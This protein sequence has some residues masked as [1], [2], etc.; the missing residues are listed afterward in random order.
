MTGKQHQREQKCH[1]Q[2]RY[3]VCK[4]YSKQPDY[5]EDEFKT[6][7]TD[8]KLSL[9]ELSDVSTDDEHSIMQEEAS[10]NDVSF[11]E[12]SR[13]YYNPE[14]KK[15]CIET[16]VLTDGLELSEDFVSN[17]H[18]RFKK[19]YYEQMESPTTCIDLCESN[20]LKYKLCWVEIFSSHKALCRSV[21]GNLEIEISGR[22]NCGKV[23]NQDEVVVEILTKNIS[24]ISCH[25][26]GKKVYGKIIGVTKT[27]E[28]R[29]PHPVFVCTL[30]DFLMYHMKPICKT[31]PKIHVF[32]EKQEKYWQVKIYKHNPQTKE[33]IPDRFISINRSKRKEY[34]FLVCYIKWNGLFPLG[35]VIGF[36]DGNCDIQTS[37]KLICLRNNVSTLYRKN[38]VIH[39]ENI[40]SRKTKKEKERNDYSDRLCVFTI[41]GDET[42]DID[43]ALSVAKTANEGYEI[44]VHISDV[45]SIIKKNDPLDLEAQDRSTSY[46]PGES[47]RPYHMLP[48][49][50]AE[51]ICSLLP[52]Q[53]R[54]VLSIFFKMDELGNILDKKIERT[55]IK[56]QERFTYCK[57]QS[58]LSSKD[59]ELNLKKELCILLSISKRLR[60]Q[61]LK[62]RSFALPFEA[63]NEESSTSYFQSIEAHHIVEE[64]MILANKTIAEELVKKFPD[65]VPLRVQS[66]PSRSRIDDWLKRHP[67]IGHFVLSLQNQR[68]NGNFE[69]SFE[70]IPDDQTALQIPIQ[71]YIWTKMTHDLKERNY[72][73][74]QRKIGTDQF[75]P[76]QANAY[77]SW[78]SFQETSSYQCSGV[79]KC[80]I[81]FS[82]DIDWYVHFTSPIRRYADIIIHRL[83]HAM[84]DNTDSPYTTDQVKT[85]CKNINSNR[86]RSREFAKQCR[87]LHLAKWLQRKPLLFHGLVASASDKSMLIRFPGIRELSKSCGEIQFQLLKLKSK[88]EIGSQD[89]T[90]L[91]TLNWQQRLYSYLEFAQ[92]G[93]SLKRGH[94]KIN[95]HQKVVFVSL[96]KWKSLID[97][98]VKQ[99]FNS[100]SM[101]RYD[102]HLLE[103]AIECKGTQDDATSESSDGVIKKLQTEFSSTFSRSQIVPIQLGCEKKGGLEVPAVHLVEITRN[104][105]CCIQHMSDPVKCFASY[106]NVH[107]GNRKMSPKEYIQRWMKIF[108]MESSTNAVKSSSIIINDLHISFR[109]NEGYDGSFVLSKSFCQERDIFIDFTWN[110]EDE[111]ETSHQTDFLCIRCELVRGVPSIA[112]ADCPPDERWIWIGHGETKCFQ[113]GKSNKKIK[114]H[115]NLHKESRKPTNSMIDAVT[116]TGLA[117]TV[118][119]LQMNDGDKYVQVLR[120]NI[121]FRLKTRKCK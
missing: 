44:G 43:D 15:E 68:L 31:V 24:L 112:K 45:T 82:L 107:A 56:S 105:K 117:Y 97:C 70:T 57:V 50:L 72:E 59:E 120:F 38:T 14:I 89:S 98:L 22:S 113:R 26:G 90:V 110:E 11:Y 12:K 5:W 108:R 55:I 20:P 41:D 81:H 8:S 119:I 95:P 39:T 62:N 29:P 65:C 114:V 61:R 85:L 111:L 32:H 36:Y 47:N 30:D 109:C 23:F 60:F 83:V 13:K 75:H 17:C 87:L 96:K 25:S 58:I 118:E 42:K 88:P 78:V 100:L 74:I 73:N 7:T 27:N 94:I 67:I 92:H 18:R 19:D 77:E 103:A 48:E 34:T 4:R 28:N 86:S 69:L 76:E 106:A 21:D 35:A 6:L 10:L 64:F 104:V 80:H 79:S 54:K 49:P 116:S 101:D 46:Y 37:L 51:N 99:N 40:I 53:R 66:K 3:K 102:E 1:P 91:V 52:N 121:L 33:L 115:F 2:D 93:T 16:E 9:P 84:I 71:R 63:L